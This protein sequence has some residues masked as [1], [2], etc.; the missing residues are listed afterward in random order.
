MSAIQD[1]VTC[2]QKVRYEMLLASL[3]LCGSFAPPPVEVQ[4]FAE[5]KKEIIP[6]C[7]VDDFKLEKTSQIALELS[8]LK[9]LNLQTKKELAKAIT[10]AAFKTGLPEKL[11]FDLIR[12]ESSFRP[13]A[14]SPIG[15]MGLTQLMPGTAKKFCKIP[16]EQIYDINANTTCGAKYLR[17]LLDDFDGDLSLALAA[18]NSGPNYIRRLQRLSTH[19]KSFKDIQH[20]IYPTTRVYVSSIQRSPHFGTV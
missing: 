20:M 9:Y 19:G 13:T 7:F 14:M 18:Y 16:P 4:K 6:V 12:R 5:V 1:L 15:A 17:R 10:N 11:I 8:H 2:L 3:C